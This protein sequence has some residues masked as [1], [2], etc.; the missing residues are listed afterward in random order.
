MEEKRTN[1]TSPP[2]PIHEATTPAG[3]GVLDEDALRKATEAW[4]RA[5]GLT[6]DT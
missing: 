6:P 1:T 2:D 5:A 3:Q 4:E